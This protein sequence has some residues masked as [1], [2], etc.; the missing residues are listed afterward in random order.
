MAKPKIRQFKIN[1]WMYIFFLGLALTRALPG[2][3]E[4]GVTQPLTRDTIE[5]YESALRANGEPQ[6]SIDPAALKISREIIE[7]QSNLIFIDQDLV[8]IG[9][10][11]GAFVLNRN[12]GK[13]REVG[14]F[15]EQATIP[16][17]FENFE[18]FK[19]LFAIAISDAFSLEDLMSMKEIGGLS[20]QKSDE[21]KSKASLEN[22]HR[23]A[24][25]LGGSL[26]SGLKSGS[27]EKFAQYGLK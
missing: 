12:P 24:L 21:R 4:S 15:T 9:H 11:L 6:R 26:L 20:R 17:L 2:H 22:F 18:R 25:V 16:T 3:A 13:D 27:D 7:M 1:Y 10:D 14:L 8:V 5:I 23:A 19:D